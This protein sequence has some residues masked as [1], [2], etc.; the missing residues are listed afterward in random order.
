MRSFVSLI[1]L[2]FA[3]WSMASPFIELPQRGVSAKN[4]AIIYLANNKLSEDIAYYYA[5]ARGVPLE[6]VIPIDLPEDKPGIEPISFE[7]KRR[8]LALSHGQHIQAYALAWN[9]PY[10]VG[11]MSIS[12]AF[13]FGYNKAYCASG[14]KPT[15]TSPFFNSVSRYPYRDFK[16]RPAMMLLAND[17]NQS[18]QVI[19]RGLLADN[20]MPKGKV[21]L[22]E[23]S[24]KNR[25]VRQL[26]FDQVGQL[27]TVKNQ[28]KLIDIQVERVRADYVKSRE[29]VLMYIAG[30]KQVEAIDT[31]QF[32]PGALADHLTSHGGKLTNSPQMSALEWLL[33]GATASYGTAHEPCN[34]LQKFPNPVVMLDAYL[35][36]DSAI[37]AYWKS[38]QMP[39]QGNFVGEPLAAP[40]SGYRLQRLANEIR[41]HSPQLRTGTYKLMKSVAFSANFASS[42]ST[43]SISKHKPYL[44]LKPP[45]SDFYQI[46]KLN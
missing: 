3:N 12:A 37:E 8:A 45:Y 4:L 14:C 27:A 2:C 46:E 22:L 30:S 39:G 23:T 5:N 38:V 43:Q 36:G 17:F 34:F 1:V 20:T 21:V 28:E 13:A 44:V 16:I 35:S 10:S 18:K 25:T 6:Q 11:C 19:D 41:L 42:Q 29:N 9:K 31:N 15:K 32:L 40:Y 26:M 24:D 7:T 33:N